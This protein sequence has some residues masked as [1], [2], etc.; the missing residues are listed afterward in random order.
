M[1]D[2]SG[3]LTPEQKQYVLDWT[4]KHWK[5]S[6]ACPIC[7]STNWNI[8]DHLVLPITLGKDS[9]LM[10]GGP[11]YPHVLLISNPCGYTIF[12]NAVIMQLPS[13]DQKPAES[14]ESSVPKVK[15]G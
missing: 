15:Q 11:G 9:S 5:S 1:P 6:G 13:V 2:D 10:L 4:K 12:F 14:T 8:G 7:G 3:K